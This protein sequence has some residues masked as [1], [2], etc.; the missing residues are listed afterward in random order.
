MKYPLGQR[1]RFTHVLRRKGVV[2]QRAEY[3][4]V[5]PDDALDR[6]TLFA[7]Q[8][9]VADIRRFGL[10][11]NNITDVFEIHWLPDKLPE[12]LE[13]V[14]MGYRTLQNG[15]THRTKEDGTIW[16]TSSTRQGALV[17]FHLRRKPVFVPL[18]FLERLGT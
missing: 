10:R 13:G 1:V 3:P 11:L 12:P 8:I 15:S 14:L 17:S 6:R 7:L 16:Q 18:E 2:V 9:Q 5:N 4:E